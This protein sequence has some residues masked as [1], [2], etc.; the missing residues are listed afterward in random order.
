MVAMQ[1]RVTAAQRHPGSI[2]RVDAFAARRGR[3]RIGPVLGV[4]LALACSAGTAAGGELPHRFRASYVLSAQG[5]DIGETLLTLE[6][7]GDGRFAYH[8]RS[9]AIGIAK[10]F[11]DERVE[12]RSEWRF[13]ESGAVQPLRYTYSRSGGKRER[14]VV[15]DFDWQDGRVH[16]TLNGHTWSMPL[17]PGMLDKLVYLLAL[18]NDLSGDMREVRYTVADGGKVKTYNLSA[19]DE[20]RLDTVVGALDTIVV[21]RSREG[22]ERVTLIWCARALGYLP[23]KVEHREDGETLRLTLTRIEGLSPP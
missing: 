10:L 23:V 21:Q 2:A 3:R 18:M 1:P 13:A 6:P 7:L 5:L 17:E 8:S 12:E 14:E 15:V 4:C 11:R 16:N 20:E 19:V 22:E 9:E